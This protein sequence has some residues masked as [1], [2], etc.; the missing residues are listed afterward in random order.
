MTMLN[1]RDVVKFAGVLA[2]TVTGKFAHANPLGL[3]IGL[4]P[5]TVRRELSR[6]FEG[7][8]KKVAAIGYKALELSEPFYGQQPG[9]LLPLLRSLQLATPSCMYPLPQDDA[10]WARNI[11]HAKTFGVE[12]MITVTRP[13]WRKN[14]DG[15]KRT[16]EL[17]N[18]LG[19]QCRKAGLW[20]AYHNHQ[21]E[22]KV[23]NGVVAYDE[24]LRSTDPKLVMMEMDC[25]WTTYAGKDPVEY[26]G[27]Y[28]GR[29]P[30]LH[31]KDLKPG[32]APSTESPKGVPYTE[33]GHG[34]I[35]W[36]RIFMAA[37]AAGVRHYYVEQDECDRPCLDSARIS[38]EYLSKLSV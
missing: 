19:E 23:M 26:F 13:E 25:F 21:F 33:V 20:I 34:V 31:I 10:Q 3:P 27:N 24:F 30:L 5:Y 37:G 28:P 2:S 11:E 16:A 8:L 29:F 12:Y 32:I 9:K 38:Y 14:L 4:Q 18:R 22:Y 6:D 7:T 15:W 35:N 17:F 1:R 36:K